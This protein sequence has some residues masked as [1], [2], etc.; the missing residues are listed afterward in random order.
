[1][2]RPAGHVSLPLAP[3]KKENTAKLTKVLKDLD[4]I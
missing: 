1:M 3:M 4:L 2:G